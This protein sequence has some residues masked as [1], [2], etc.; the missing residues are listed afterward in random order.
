MATKKH[1]FKQQSEEWKALIEKAF[2]RLLPSATATPKRLHQAMHYSLNAGGKRLRP[3]LVLAGEA[4]FPS[5]L[6]PFP[7]A[8]AVE[9]LHSYSLIHDDLPSIDNSELRRGKP[10][11]HKA[12]DP[13]TALLA[14]DA[15]LTHSFYLLS[16]HY[17]AAIAQALI[18]DLAQAAGSQAL[19]GGQMEDILAEKQDQPLEN[20]ATQLLQRIHQGKTA[21]LI[22]SSLR[23]GLHLGQ[24]SAQTLAYATQLGNALGLAFQIIDDILDVTASSEVLGKDT[25]S[26][27]KHGKL[28]YPAI[29]GLEKSKFLAK[30]TGQEA[31]AACEKLGGNNQFLLWLIQNLE[32][33]IY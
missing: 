27:V 17:P 11:C 2:D 30:T 28:T 15:L 22:A 6:D 1:A 23:L 19:I 26:D 12:F 13:A 16:T 25:G 4:L 29:Y 5:Q 31:R 33:R 3:I 8:V 20:E 21:A 7:A 9:C 10:S 24:A 32:E 18:A 14:G